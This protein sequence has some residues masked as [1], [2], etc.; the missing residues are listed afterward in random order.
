MKW[1]TNVFTVPHTLQVIRGFL[2]AE[3]DKIVIETKEK[4]RYAITTTRND[5]KEN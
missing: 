2:L 3:A 5:Q 4:G 1:K